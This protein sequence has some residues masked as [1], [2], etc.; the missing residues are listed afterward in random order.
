M[1]RA[2]SCA[3]A[4]GC[5]GELA[6]LQLVEF[7]E[8]DELV[9]IF[10]VGSVARVLKPVSPAFVVFVVE[11]EEV[12]VAAARQ[13]ELGV[14]LV[15]G[16]YRCVLS[17]AFAL[18]IVVLHYIGA[19]PRAARLDAKV[20]V[21]HTGQVARARTAFQKTLRQRDT[22]GDAVEVHL[23]DSQVFIAVDVAFVE[24]TL[25]KAGKGCCQGEGDE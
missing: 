12:G 1:A 20:V 2:G 13:Q 5:I 10:G 17:E 15:A 22:G 21:G 8:A 25:G 7:D 4:P 16:F 24:R 6:S 3:A 18:A 11:L 9:G 23:L 14:V 19:V